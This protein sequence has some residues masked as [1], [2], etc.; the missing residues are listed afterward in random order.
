MRIFGLIGKNINYS[1]SA[2]IFNKKFQI[3]KITD[4]IYKIYDIH[5]IEVIQELLEQ[6]PNLSGLNITIPY[7]ERIMHFIHNCSDESL[8]IGAVNTIKILSNKQLIGYNTDVYGFE[9]SFLIKKKKYHKNALILGTGGAAKAVAFVLKKLNISYLYV[10]RTKKQ[11]TITY[12]DITPN[13]INNYQIII[14]CSPIGTYPN[15]HESPRLPYDLLSSTHYMYDLI[16]NPY[17]TSFLRQGK[18]MGCTVQNG[19]K[20]L[21]L[22]ADQ[23]WKIWNE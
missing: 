16:Y 7:K 13:I 23:S 19:L 6:I 17:E 21:H 5:N 9:K 12:L 8:N 22:Q 14:N 1:Y 10:S 20:M 3:E 4:A 15:I 18:N 2:T 11:D